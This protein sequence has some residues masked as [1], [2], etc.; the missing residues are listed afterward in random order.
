MGL[1]ARMTR[2]VTGVLESLRYR[3]SNEH[4]TCPACDA[5]TLALI[6][7]L[8]VHRRTDGQRVGL[9]CGCRNCGLVFANPFPTSDELQALYSSDGE[10]GKR[11]PEEAAKPLSLVYIR[12]FFRPV[13]SFFDILHPPAGGR[14]LDIGCGTGSM[15]DA[16]QPLGW[17]TWGPAG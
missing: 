5:A 1:I 13:A 9:V 4:A 11:R 17:E 10:W 3:A 7:P 16:L 12:D 2:A 14:V 6:E 15:L 8:P